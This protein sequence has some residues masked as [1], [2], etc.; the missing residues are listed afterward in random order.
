MNTYIKECR[1]IGYS[2]GDTGLYDYKVLPRGS[3]GQIRVSLVLEP[4]SANQG[5][6]V[7]ISSQNAKGGFLPITIFGSDPAPTRILPI[8]SPTLIRPASNI[9]IYIYPSISGGVLSGGTQ[10]VDQIK[11]YDMWVRSDA[12]ETRI[13]N[14]AGPFFY[15]FSEAGLNWT[16]YGI[17]EMLNYVDTR[18]LT[19]TSGDSTVRSAVLKFANDDNFGARD[20]STVNTNF[21]NVPFNPA[22]SGSTNTKAGYFG[23]NGWTNSRAYPEA[24]GTGTAQNPQHPIGT[25]SNLT[26]YSP[27]G[28]QKCEFRVPTTA[29]SQVQAFFRACQQLGTYFP[30]RFSYH[31]PIEVKT[32]ASADVTF[33]ADGSLP[34]S[35]NFGHWRSGL[36]TENGGAKH[37]SLI[38]YG[39]TSYNPPTYF[40]LE[41]DRDNGYFYCEANPGRS[42]EAGVITA[43]RKIGTT[44]SNA[45]CQMLNDALV[46]VNGSA[47]NP[48]STTFEQVSKMSSSQQ[49]VAA[50]ALGFVGHK[51]GPHDYYH[52]KWR[53]PFIGNPLAR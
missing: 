10:K 5:G 44:A 23:G 32:F 35:G 9:R 4:S 46:D 6:T 16:R 33:P 37:P 22:M 42:T 3:D 39:D 7:G 43:S 11:W 18:T 28:E 31:K 25:R 29:S 27:Y 30:T 12:R 20:F 21:T 8:L 51:E 50:S 36:L 19:N 34:D 41:T 48:G 52:C 45:D 17:S 47:A 24:V 1:D 14:G 38:K 40:H 26:R 15:I 53:A 49:R 13:N 2:R